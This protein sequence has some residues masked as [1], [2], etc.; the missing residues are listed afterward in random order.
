MKITKSSII[1]LPG[2][3][4]FLIVNADKIGDRNFCLLSTLEQPIEMRVAEMR[5]NVGVAEV[6]EYTG[7]NYKD[8][9]FQLLINKQ[10][11]FRFLS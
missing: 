10:N 1:E 3:A 9:L 4:K 2:G 7:K 8:I 11:M 5:I 6:K